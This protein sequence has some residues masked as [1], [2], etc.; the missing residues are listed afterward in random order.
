MTA[1]CGIAHIYFLIPFWYSPQ[2]KADIKGSLSLC[3]HDLV[4]GSLNMA[5]VPLLVASKGPQTTG[6]PPDKANSPEQE[7][8]RS[9]STEPVH[10]PRP[11]FGIPRII[12][13]PTSENS[14][15][16]EALYMD[17]KPD[18]QACDLGDLVFDLRKF[19][20]SSELLESV[21]SFLSWI[22]LFLVS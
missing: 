20:C 13:S 21:E 12:I 8:Y 17:D 9:T 18:L 16:E 15:T 4:T 22:V 5:T 19:D 3:D 6:S 1:L 11:C 7:P 2:D 10:F 14:L